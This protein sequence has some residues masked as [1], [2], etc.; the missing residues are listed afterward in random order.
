[1]YILQ[2]GPDFKILAKNEMEHPCFA[3]PAISG[4]VL[5]VRTI[6][7]LMAIQAE[8]SEPSKSTETEP[9]PKASPQTRLNKRFIEVGDLRPIDGP[10]AQ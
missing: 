10:S 7:N 6:E 5:Y 9:T 8:H 1:M 3:T 4:G 2:A